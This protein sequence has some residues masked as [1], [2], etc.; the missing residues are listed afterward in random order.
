MEVK[1]QELQEEEFTA[2]PRA[3]HKGQETNLKNTNPY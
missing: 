2:L 1:E 3:A